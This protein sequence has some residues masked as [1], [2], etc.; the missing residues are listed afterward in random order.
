[1]K[2][3]PCWYDSGKNHMNQCACGIAA[4]AS[5]DIYVI[6]RCPGTVPLSFGF[7]SCV[8]DTLHV[9]K[10]AQDDHDYEVIKNIII[11]CFNLRSIH[12]RINMQ[13]VFSF[14]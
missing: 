12:I 7:K 14:Q 1:M 5:S 2:V 10:K 9:M 6:D 8:E 11:H 4:R 3:T 13:P